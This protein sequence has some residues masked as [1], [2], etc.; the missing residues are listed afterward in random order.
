M[1][2]QCV[3]LTYLCTKSFI[4]VFTSSRLSSLPI[5]AFFHSGQSCA[6][7]VFIFLDVWY[8]SISSRHRPIC[9]SLVVKFGCIV[10]NGGKE[11][12]SG[13][14]QAGVEHNWLVVSG[15]CCHYCAF[16]NEASTQNPLCTT[17]LEGRRHRGILYCDTS[18]RL[19]QQNGFVYVSSS[20][21][22]CNNKLQPRSQKGS[23]LFLYRY[24]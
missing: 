23:L 21:T 24:V 16:F 22:A 12:N 18:I 15:Q 9:F 4:T 13:N 19:E 17:D 6:T 3:H 7:S 2:F 5:S 10:K 8:E 11:Q 1:C 14:Y 20:G